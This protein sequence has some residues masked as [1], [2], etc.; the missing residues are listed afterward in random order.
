MTR[1]GIAGPFTHAIETREMLRI[2]NF[3]LRDEYQDDVE[4]IH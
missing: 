2:P 3:L 4:L 1:N